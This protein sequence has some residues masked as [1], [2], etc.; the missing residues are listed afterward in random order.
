MDSNV[1]LAIQCVGILLLTLLSLFMHGSIRTASLRYWTAAW[2]ILS[3]ALVSLFVGFRV[4]YGQSLLYS[5]Y[6]LGEYMFGLLFLAGCRNY[7]HGTVL[8]RKHRVLLIPAVVTALVLPHVS[9]DFNDLFIIHS[10]AMA[11]LFGFAFMTIRSGLKGKE[12]TPGKRVMSAALLF[13]TIDF[14]HYVP[15]FS[16][17]KG[18]LGITVPSG[19]LQ[20]TSM[21]DLILEVLLG[22]GTM[23]I[24]MEGVRREVELAN[25]KLTEARDKL[26]LLAKID[27]LTEALNRHAFHSLL[28]HPESGGYAETSGCV[29]VIDI[30]N[31]KPINDTLGHSAGDKAIRSV[32][33]LTHLCSGPGQLVARMG[34]DEFLVLM[35]KLPEEDARKRLLGLNEILQKNCARWTGLPMTVT[36]SQGVAGFGSLGELANAIETAD[37]AMYGQRQQVR[38]GAKTEREVLV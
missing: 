23:M 31:L 13:L 20:Y 27:P 5:L 4:N 19:Y 36:V 7:V 21:L 2:A 10:I 29:A 22:F 24:L 1:G 18:L 8:T 38:Q 14:V 11:G 15:L 28:R 26:E 37:K 34:G 25:G 32:A 35:F 30:D 33:R 3:L 9:A 17:R 6:F 16:A 12:H